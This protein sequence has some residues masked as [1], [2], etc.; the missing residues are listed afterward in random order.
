VGL[1]HAVVGN[2]DLL[3]AQV[4]TGLWLFRNRIITQI[5]IA[6]CLREMLKT[7]HVCC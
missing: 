7:G 5:I 4:K 2:S 6:K 1:V 3:S